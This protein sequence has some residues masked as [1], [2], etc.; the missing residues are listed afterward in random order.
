MKKIHNTSHQIERCTKQFLNFLSEAMKAR[1]ARN[2]REAFQAERARTQALDASDGT[3]KSERRGDYDQ[4]SIF[5]GTLKGYQLKGMNWLANLYDQ[6]R[7]SGR[8]FS[9][10][11][12]KVP[13]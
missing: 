9:N 10:N 13:G 1:A 5:R 3:D 2:A 7:D 11:E 8:L 6:V 4:P 12:S